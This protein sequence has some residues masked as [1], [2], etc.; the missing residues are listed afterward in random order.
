LRCTQVERFV[1]R[2]LRAADRGPRLRKRPPSDRCKNLAT[3]H[4][5]VPGTCTDA[6]HTSR[7]VLR[8]LRERARPFRRVSCRFGAG[9]VRSAQRQLYR[10]REDAWYLGRPGAHNLQS[11]RRPLTVP[12]FPASTSAPGTLRTTKPPPE[13]PSY[14]PGSLTYPFDPVVT[15]RRALGRPGRR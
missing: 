15:G 2:F 11:F 1:L 14:V 7:R 13:V 12:Y 4:G 10:V 6:T 3:I 5:R 9:S 8:G